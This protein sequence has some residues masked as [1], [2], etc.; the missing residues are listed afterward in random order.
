MAPSREVAEG[1]EDSDEE[2][3]AGRCEPRSKAIHDR[4]ARNP[5]GTPLKRKAET[6]P[7]GSGAGAASSRPWR[8]SNT[9]WVDS[10]AKTSG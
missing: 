4:T 8:S 5:A 10:R 9:V 6:A 3:A 2:A 1:K 7:E